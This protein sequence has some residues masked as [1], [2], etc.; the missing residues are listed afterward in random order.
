MKISPVVFCLVSILIFN[1]CSKTEELVTI[2]RPEQ[3]LFASR[4]PEDVRQWLDKYKAIA[5][6]YFGTTRFG[7]D[8]ALVNELLK[9]VNDKELDVLYKQVN[10]E[11]GTFGDIQNLLSE[12]FNRIHENFPDFKPPKV[13]TMVSGFMGPDLIISD[14]LVVIGLDYFAGPKA[15]YRPKGLPAYILRRYQKEFIAPAIVFALSDRF[16]K[17]NQQDQTLLADMVYYGKGYVFTKAMLP[18]TPDSLIIGYTDQQ[19]TQTNN[20][21]ED[22]WAYFIDAKLLY[23]VS[24]P[25]KNRYLTERPFTAEI[26]TRSPGAIGRWLGWRIVGKYYDGKEPGIKALM[27][28]DNAR[29]IFEQSGYKGFKDDNE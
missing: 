28:N 2:E 4:K 24:P 20:V 29:Q 15:K 11:F 10:A 7:Q 6:A 17:T 25:V 3:E 13:A 14:T 8:S 5:Q 21:Q 26:G 12:A 19:L 23:E 9:R 16:N 22:I 1:S 18:Q 27:D